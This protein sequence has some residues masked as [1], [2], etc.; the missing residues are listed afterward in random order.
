[1]YRVA[2]DINIA[3]GFLR[4]IYD[5]TN[6][7]AVLDQINPTFSSITYIIGKVDICFQ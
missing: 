3:I 5:V 4:F 1:M 7:R 6:V 2:V